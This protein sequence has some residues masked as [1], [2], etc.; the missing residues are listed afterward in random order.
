[1]T[2]RLARLAYAAAV[3]WGSTALAFPAS[4]TE[5]SERTVR[6]TF[7]LSVQGHAAPGNVLGLVEGTPLFAIATVTF[8]GNGQC[9]SSDKI[10]VRGQTIPDLPEVSVETSALALRDSSAC[11]YRVEPS[12]FGTFSV[13]FDEPV[14][15]TTTTTFVITDRD[16]I[17]LI[18]NN[19]ELGIYGLG[20]L[21]RQK[22]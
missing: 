18:A 11:T 13:T 9:S 15:T 4:A 19:T 14:P 22:P 20:V 16:E 17:Q 12:G 5:F 3:A 7:T 1:M 6:G 10:V 8:D 2:A 21:E